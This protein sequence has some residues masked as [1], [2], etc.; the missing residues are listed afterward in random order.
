MGEF[1]S[2]LFDTSDF[3]ARWQ[4]GNWTAGH[5]WMHILADVTI[6]GAYVAIPALILYFMYKKPDIVFPRVGWFFA[7]FIFFCGMGHLMEATIFWWPNYR[8][9]GLIKVG[10]AAASWATV[11]AV[12][13]LIPRALELPGLNALISDLENEVVE[14]ERAEAALR[15]RNQDLQMLLHIISHDLREPLRGIR[16]LSSLL[17]DRYREQLDASAHDILERIDSSGQRLDVLIHDLTHFTKAQSASVPRQS[18]ALS[19]AV[20]AAVDRLR[21]RIDL[22]GAEINVEPNLPTV[23]G[24]PNWITQAI[25]NLLSNAIK[26]SEEG[27]RPRIDVRGHVRGGHAGVVVLDRG[28]GVDADSRDTIF[29]LFRR[30][31]NA[32]PEGT[33]TGLAIVKATAARHGGAAWYEPRE[34]GGS[35]FFVTFSTAAR[36]AE[37]EA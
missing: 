22:T 23:S 18:V 25:Y 5:G 36:P 7:A 26:Y 24:D 16:G 30:G 19:D 29:E 13:P 9:D 1:L 27:A 11:I 15:E 3:P 6:F 14:R 12:A 28:P 37:S 10:T 20:S 34:G 31:T 33:G 32:K 21:A 17:S 2:K 4:C 8:L 35:A